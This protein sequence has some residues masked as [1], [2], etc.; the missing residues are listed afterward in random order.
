M[1]VIILSC[2]SHYVTHRWR[3]IYFSILFP[4]YTSVFLLSG[5]PWWEGLHQDWWKTAIFFY[6]G[7]KMEAVVV[8]RSAQWEHNP[9]NKT[10]TLQA[11]GVYST[12]IRVCIVSTQSGILPPW[13]DQPAAMAA[14]SSCC[15]I[16]TSHYFLF[17]IRAITGRLRLL[18]VT[19]RRSS[20][21]EEEMKHLQGYQAITILDNLYSGAA[22]W[23]LDISWE[24]RPT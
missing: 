22:S 18:I 13:Y 23:H 4:R 17:H 20:S 15:C 14:E 24:I 2:C 12:N 5:L 16:K 3:C 9:Q 1:R 11:W 21:A 10:E 8:I 6:H 19:H 7:K